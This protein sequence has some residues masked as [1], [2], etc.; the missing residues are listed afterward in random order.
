MK[1][2]TNNWFSN[3]KPG[4]VV[5]FGANSIAIILRVLHQTAYL[6]TN[7][8]EIETCRALLLTNK[9]SVNEF[10]LYEDINKEVETIKQ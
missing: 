9:I 4:T 6:R 1:T 8:L 3:L 7:D 2:S 5:W 10:T